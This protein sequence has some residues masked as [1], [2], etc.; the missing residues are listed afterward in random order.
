MFG[1]LGECGG[2][3][4]EGGVWYGWWASEVG[5]FVR[6]IRDGIY[7]SMVGI[8]V[9]GTRAA[10]VTGTIPNPKTAGARTSFLATANVL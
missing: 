7:R 5:P 6:E 3:L 10:V 8:V 1:H 2:M 4:N 9:N